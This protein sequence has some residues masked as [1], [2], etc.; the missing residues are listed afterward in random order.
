MAQVA[1]N[2]ETTEVGTSLQV[3]DFATTVRHRGRQQRIQ[4]V[5]VRNYT[6]ASLAGSGQRQN[7]G[8]C[9]RTRGRHFMNVSAMMMLGPVLMVP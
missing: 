7:G 1:V 3:S 8:G 4:A 6:I 5:G 9:N 2:D